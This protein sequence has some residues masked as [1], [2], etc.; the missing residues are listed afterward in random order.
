MV[1]F[2]F[3]LYWILVIQ[4]PLIGS[5]LGLGKQWN[6]LELCGS[7]P[8]GLLQGIRKILVPLGISMMVP[9]RILS[10]S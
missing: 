6:D 1:P 8:R 9:R 2:E 4:L 10:R 5:D 3:F 7:T